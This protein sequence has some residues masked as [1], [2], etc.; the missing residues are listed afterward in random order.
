MPALQAKKNCSVTI[1]KQLPNYENNYL[2][3]EKPGIG[4]Y[5]ISLFIEGLVYF[6]IVLLIDISDIKKSCSYRKPKSMWNQENSQDLEK[7]ERT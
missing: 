3:F 1:K 6:T 2:A 7:S 4:C 5:L